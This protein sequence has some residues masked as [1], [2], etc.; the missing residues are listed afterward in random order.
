MNSDCSGRLTDTV[1]TTL[2]NG[3]SF[4]VG[5]QATCS[6]NCRLPD[7]NW[8]C[9]VQNNAPKSIRNKDSPALKPNITTSKVFQDR[10]TEP[11][12]II[13]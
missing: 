2:A 4:A 10:V 6:G 7:C 12:G 3:E 11:L 5:G 1:K 9:N 8:Y 13:H